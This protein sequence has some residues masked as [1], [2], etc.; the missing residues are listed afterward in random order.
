MWSEVLLAI[1]ANVGSFYFGVTIAWSS[2]AGPQVIE[3]ENYPFWVTKNQFGLIVACISLGGITSCIPSGIIRHKI[4]TKKT[5]FYFS[6][7]GVIGSILIT[8]AD[9]LAMLLI[10]RYLIGISLGCFMFLVQI[11]V[12][13]ISS[14]KNRG[15]LLNF[16]HILVHLGVL[17]VYVLG[18]IVSLKMLN[19]ICGAIPLF[20]GIGFLLMPETKPYL[21]SKGKYQNDINANTAELSKL[22][23]N[24]DKPEVKKKTIVE[25][26]Q[27]RAT[28]RAMIIMVFQFFFFQMSGAV[29]VNFYAKLIFIEASVNINPGLASI[30]N[31]CVLCLSATVSVFYVRKFGRRM[32][33]FTFNSLSVVS[34]I[35][36]GIFFSLKDMGYSIDNI[37]W[38][39]LVS[40]CLNSIAFC[41]GIAPV[42]YGLLG[43]LFTIEAKKILAPM[44]QIFNQIMTFTI[45]ISFPF[46]SS[47]I[48]T[49]SVFL[50]F[51]ITTFIDIIFGYYFIP[52]TKGKSFDE[53]QEALSK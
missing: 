9:N 51:A 10:G 17:F 3:N 53:I 30:I 2:P 1:F 41:L 15:S 11:Y 14:D 8:L 50:I 43:E 5:I 49:G 20:Y 12:G 44:A 39:P 28:R 22:K 25:L 40:L 38:L 45:G 37:K 34:L 19:I 31:V 27:M 7:P 13:E 24:N 18:Q 29:A 4:G 21:I 42:T 16:I 33:L 35:G 36:L 52:E 46:L 47:V 32:M 26:L 48:G 23:Q 6:F